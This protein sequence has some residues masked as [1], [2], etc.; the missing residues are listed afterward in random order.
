MVAKQKK[1]NQLSGTICKLG[2]FQM[3]QSA[4]PMIPNSGDQTSSNTQVIYGFSL[5]LL[6]GVIQAWI[7]VM[8]TLHL[9]KVQCA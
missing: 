3:K 9:N 6:Q 8:V 7:E 5:L 4:D 2:R 1:S